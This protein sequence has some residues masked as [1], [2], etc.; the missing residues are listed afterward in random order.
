MV[1]TERAWPGDT[2]RTTPLLEKHAPFEA[3]KAC[4]AQLVPEGS[5]CDWYML[6]SSW[7]APWGM[8]SS[9]G[10]SQVE[11]SR[12]SALGCLCAQLP[13]PAQMVLGLARGVYAEA[14]ELGSTGGG[15][16]PG[17]S[18]WSGA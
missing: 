14:Q 2:A 11:P 16:P 4:S 1:G 6:V 15:W 10:L 7:L 13:Q 12:T 9:F 8:F 5:R 18:F 3:L 17:G